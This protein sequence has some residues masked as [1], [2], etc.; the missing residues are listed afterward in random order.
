[1][2]R[3]AGQLVGPQSYGAMKKWGMGVY[4][5]AGSH[6][7]LDN[8]PCYY[9][10]I[11]NLYK[12]EHTQRADLTKPEKLKESRTDFWRRARSCWGKAAGL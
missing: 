9:D 6:V 2:L 3:T 1:V 12:L 4:L 11:L 5:D 8:G 10:G 7:N